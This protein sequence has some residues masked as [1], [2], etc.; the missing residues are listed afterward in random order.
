MKGTILHIGNWYVFIRKLGARY[1]HIGLVLPNAVAVIGTYHHLVAHRTRFAD[2]LPSWL[3]PHVCVGLDLL[4]V[5][6][7]HNVSHFNSMRTAKTSKATLNEIGATKFAFT[8]NLV[9]I[10]V[11][12]SLLTGALIAKLYNTRNTRS[13]EWSVR[14]LCDLL[15]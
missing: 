4:W 15:I 5:T 11:G 9:I 14:F 7:T 8:F 6:Y 1:T 13:S 10:T 12:D 2:E 3:R